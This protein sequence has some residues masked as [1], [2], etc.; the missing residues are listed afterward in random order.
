VKN[1]AN[2]KVAH[3]FFTISKR[4][5]RTTWLF[6]ALAYR[7]L[8]FSSLLIPEKKFSL[9]NLQIWHGQ[10]RIGAANQGSNLGTCHL[11]TKYFYKINI[12]IEK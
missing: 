2:D 4:G 6:R 7:Q 11:F 1:Q 9:V 5:W 3:A 10:A 12:F 8:F